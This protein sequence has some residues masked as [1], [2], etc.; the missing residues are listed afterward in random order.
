MLSMVRRNIEQFLV[1]DEENETAYL[2]LP[3]EG[4][5]WFWYGDEIETHA[6]YLKLLSRV[7][8]KN[9]TASRLVK[10]L[11]N[12]RKHATYWRSTRDTAFCVESFA[13]Y[14]RATG[15]AKPDM[16]IEIWLDGEMQKE[17]A[18]TSENLFSFDNKFVLT[19]D[20]VTTGE[21]KLEV[22]RQGSGSVYFN[23]YLTNF[24]LE[25][26]ITKTGLEIK[27]E[28]KFYKLTRDPDAQTK[29]TGAR[30]QALDQR[31]EKYI[32][33]PIQNL[34][35][36]TSGDLIEVELEVASKND[37]EYIMFEDHRAAGLEPVEV[38]SGY[39]ANGLGAYM[40]LRDDRVTFF[41]RQLA[42]GNHS[43][44]Y[45][46]RAEIPGQFSAL[47]AQGSGMYAPELKANSD[48]IKVVVVD[49]T[50]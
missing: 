5:W 7:D 35:S 49:K 27:V 16:T 8:P 12:N 29:V 36:V 15:E 4:Y 47:P 28:R 24:T 6:A 33:T 1:Q 43:I 41:V 20:K 39:A 23:A 50:E 46:L 21:H 14:L 25:D 30:G 37:Y 10:Y 42:R 32:R 48:E 22:R 31:V 13:D 26:P 44:A 2:R 11:L 40:E 17:V 9:P 3:N 34:D 19:G 45:R 18:V 38:R